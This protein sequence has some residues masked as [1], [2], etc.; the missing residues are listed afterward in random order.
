MKLSG[1]IVQAE[2]RVNVATFNPNLPSVPNL[3]YWASN[4]PGS[5]KVLPHVFLADDALP[6]KQYLMKPFSFRNQNNEQ[7][8]F[9]YRLSRATRTVE[10]AFEI[11]SNTFRCLLKPIPLE[12]EEVQNIVLSCICLL[13]FLMQENHSEYCSGSILNI[14]NVATGRVQFSDYFDTEVSVPCQARMAGIE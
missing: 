7:K 12:Q 5:N 1:I 8:I 11:L 4:F 6:L 14:E 9:S 13:N 3:A 2:I 10:N